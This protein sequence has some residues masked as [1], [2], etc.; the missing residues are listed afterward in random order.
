MATTAAA[1]MQ[2]LRRGTLVPIGLHPKS[3]LR[4]PP[5]IAAFA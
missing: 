2:P 4:S 5:L 3:L 1:K